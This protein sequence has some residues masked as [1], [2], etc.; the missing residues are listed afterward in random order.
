MEPRDGDRQGLRILRWHW[1][2]V[3]V[4]VV[5]AFFGACVLVGFGFILLPG[6]QLD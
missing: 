6:P 5:V 2:V 4:A 1:L 3:A